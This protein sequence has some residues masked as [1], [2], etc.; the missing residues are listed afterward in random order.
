ML[1]PKFYPLQESGISGHAWG[2]VGAGLLEFCSK[3]TQV[4][5][6]KELI[7]VEEGTHVQRL[8]QGQQME[9]NMSEYIMV[10]ATQI[11]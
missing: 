2:L 1:E 9:L 6:R 10:S 11:V 7:P 3:T 8:H 5:S 4:V